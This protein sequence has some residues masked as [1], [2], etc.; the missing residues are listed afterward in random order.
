[1]KEGQEK[2]TRYMDQPFPCDFP[3]SIFHL[4]FFIARPSSFI[5]HPSSFILF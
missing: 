3:F 2:H 4:S 5:L 1:M